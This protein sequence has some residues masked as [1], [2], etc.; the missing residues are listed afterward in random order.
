MVCIT[1]N[2]STSLT[3]LATATTRYVRMVYVGFCFCQTRALPTPNKL[4]ANRVLI[5]WSFGF[6]CSSFGCCSVV[7]IVFCGTPLQ[8]IGAIVKFVF[9]LVVYLW[10]SIGVW[11]KRHRNQAAYSRRCVNAVHRENCFPISLTIQGNSQFFPFCAVDSA[12]FVNGC[13]VQTPDIA[14][15]ADF[16]IALKANNGTPFF[17][18]TSPSSVTMCN[19]HQMPT[20]L[21]SAINSPVRIH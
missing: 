21:V 16:V 1:P 20:P 9:V 7:N 12:I 6:G 14:E 17:Y 8:V 2:I 11:Q 5:Y 10:E 18:M 4:A 15:V 3:Q 13:P 19:G